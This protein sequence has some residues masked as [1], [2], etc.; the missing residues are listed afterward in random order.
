MLLSCHFP[1]L[2]AAR[3]VTGFARSQ[4]SLPTRWLLALPSCFLTAW[5]EYTGI[6]LSK[7]PPQKGKVLYPKWTSAPLYQRD[8]PAV[9][10]VCLK[11]CSP[12][13]W[14]ETL[15]MVA[16]G[17]GSL[18]RSLSCSNS[19]KEETVSSTVHRIST[20]ELGG[21]STWQSLT[22]ASNKSKAW[23]VNEP[24]RPRAGAVSQGPF[25]QRGGEG[26][27]ITLAP[28]VCLGESMV[29]WHWPLQSLGRGICDHLWVS[30]KHWRWRI[31]T[32][33][34]FFFITWVKVSLLNTFNLWGYWIDRL[35]ASNWDKRNLKTKNIYISWIILSHCFS[36][37]SV[38]LHF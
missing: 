36:R 24:P 25:C 5:D 14:K 18:S 17:S 15:F 30:E 26:H 37:F 4:S 19:I 6:P 23:R 27:R 28:G 21:P 34:V 7:V 8:L 31:L 35:P 10:H 2:P 20:W 16:S 13:H 22:C 12:L 9:R 1:P 33:I 11:G 3:Q 32:M 38:T 29:M